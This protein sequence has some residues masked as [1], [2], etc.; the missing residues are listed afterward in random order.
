MILTLQLILHVYYKTSKW[1]VL[2]VPSFA[3][4]SPDVL[5][6]FPYIHTPYCLLPERKFFAIPF[7]EMDDD[8]PFLPHIDDVIDLII[9]G[10]GWSKRMTEKNLDI[11][12]S[13]ALLSEI[14]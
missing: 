3:V 4:V 12:K 13:S 1:Y 2:N 8:Q 14:H 6:F 9:G 5:R 11:S 10:D 7:D